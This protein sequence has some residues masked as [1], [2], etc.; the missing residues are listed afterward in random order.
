MGGIGENI[1]RGG[2]QRNRHVR[3]D[4][5]RVVNPALQSET[6]ELRT[7]FHIISAA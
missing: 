6:E 3:V 2:K 4:G 1:V 5:V 7:D